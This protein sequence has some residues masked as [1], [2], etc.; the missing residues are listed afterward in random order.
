MVKN[1][2]FISI[3]NHLSLVFVQMCNILSERE[4]DRKYGL[5]CHYDYFRYSVGLEVV[6]QIR[7]VA[8]LAH[9]AM[10][11]NSCVN[12]VIYNFFSGR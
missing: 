2:G 6:P 8:L 12:P 11:F 3:Q 9:W 1:C 10:F 4:F 5:N 7:T